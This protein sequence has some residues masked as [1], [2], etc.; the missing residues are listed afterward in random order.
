MNNSEKGFLSCNNWC[1]HCGSEDH[2]CINKLCYTGSIVMSILSLSISAL[3]VKYLNIDLNWF[4]TIA[5]ILVTIF[6][7]SGINVSLIANSKMWRLYILGI[8]DGITQANPLLIIPAIF[9]FSYVIQDYK[10]KKKEE[11]KLEAYKDKLS[12]FESEIGRIDTEYIPKLESLRDEF[13]KSRA[14]DYYD[15]KS[16]INQINN[17]ISHLRS[18]QIKLKAEHEECMIKYTEVV[19]N[20]KSSEVKSK[21]HEL[22]EGM[23]I[24]SEDIR[25]SKWS[26]ENLIERRRLNE[27][28]S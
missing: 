3:I 27:T 19:I 25:E 15:Y 10:F 9:G 11:K 20:F 4:I 21:L 28:N 14:S 23:K 16:E 1:D 5:F 8:Y 18:Q 24:L 17:L 6:I 2:S 12:R 26:T 22:L 13:I 7:S